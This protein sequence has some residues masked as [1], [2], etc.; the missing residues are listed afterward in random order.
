M[1]CCLACDN[2]QLPK[3]IVKGGCGVPQLYGKGRQ[4][5]SYNG[6]FNWMFLH[7]RKLFVSDALGVGGAPHACGSPCPAPGI[8][9]IIYT[10]L[11]PGV[12]FGWDSWG[13]EH[14][15][16][17][18][19]S[20]PA[21]PSAWPLLTQHQEHNYTCNWKVTYAKK[22]ITMYHANISIHCINATVMY[23]SIN[24]IL[25]VC[26]CTSSLFHQH[27]W[28]V[29]QRLSWGSNVQHIYST[30]PTSECLDQ[31]STNSVKHSAFMNLF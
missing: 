19:E 10:Q 17:G 2:I 7:P 30:F 1:H 25:I 20:G 15:R 26:T 22:R 4:C 13:E 5:Y 16:L 18:P 29:T 28:Y 31:W 12:G 11:Y 3:I 9:H 23:R 6:P 24:T 14:P 21:L 8:M 27:S